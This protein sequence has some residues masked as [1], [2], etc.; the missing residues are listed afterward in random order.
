MNL[1]LDIF[2]R[3]PKNLPINQS[4]CLFTSMLRNKAHKPQHTLDLITPR[5]K[6]NRKKN[7]QTNW[8][9]SQSTFLFFFCK[10]R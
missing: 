9:T 4:S 10:Y 8:D 6:K 3:D 5:N 2:Y 1:H 7:K